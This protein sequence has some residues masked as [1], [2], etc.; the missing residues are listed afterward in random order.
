MYSNEKGTKGFLHCLFKSGAFLVLK[1]IFQNIFLQ[2]SFFLVLTP[3]TCFRFNDSHIFHIHKKWRQPL[4]YRLFSKS[5]LMS[6]LTEP[7]QISLGFVITN[8]KSSYVAKE[9]SICLFLIAKE[10]ALN[11]QWIKPCV[12]LVCNF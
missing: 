7:N 2:L 5:V 12:P 9:D 6:T 11:E 1:G 10:A 3:R 4:L 8:D